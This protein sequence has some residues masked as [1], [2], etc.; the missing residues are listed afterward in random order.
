MKIQLRRRILFSLQEKIF[1]LIKQGNGDGFAAET[2]R[3]DTYGFYPLGT[4]V[5]L[6][7]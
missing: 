4:P 5:S 3:V 6:V 7:R 2:K 1:H